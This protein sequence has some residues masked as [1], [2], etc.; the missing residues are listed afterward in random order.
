M[1]SSADK[2]NVLDGVLKDVVL[3]ISESQE[4]VQLLVSY[5]ISLSKEDLCSASTPIVLLSDIFDIY[6]IVECETL[7]GFV[8]KNVS[9]W[10]DELFFS[11]CK[12]NL[13]RMCNDLLR[14]LSRSQNTIFRGRILLFLASFFPFSERSG[15]FFV[16]ILWI[17][18]VIYGLGLNLVSEF[19]LEANEYK[20]DES[21]E[22]EAME[23]GGD[24]STA[25]RVDYNLYNKFLTLQDFLRNP[26]QCYVKLRWAAFALV[27]KKN[28]WSIYFLFKK[29]IVELDWHVYDFPKYETG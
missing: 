19:N 25:L 12:N 26:T 2:R 23:T 22:D 27:R 7:F 5:A 9:I 18:G 17:F 21:V 6:T 14:R 4:D 20:K 3:D 24:E 13:L 16:I 1:D 29:K 8:E 15:K 11:A 10:K 28:P